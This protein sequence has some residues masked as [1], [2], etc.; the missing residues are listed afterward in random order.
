MKTL[1]K[2]SILQVKIDTCHIVANVA[3][4]RR[5]L[6]QVC[7]F[8]TIRGFHWGKLEMSVQ[9]WGMYNGENIADKE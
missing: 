8:F 2:F 6:G 4:N 9:Y 7:L 5:E 1:D 3:I